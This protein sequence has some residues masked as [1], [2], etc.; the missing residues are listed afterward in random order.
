M[1]NLVSLDDYGVTEK[2]GIPVVSSRRVAQ[3][4]GKRHDNVL[5]A[6]DNLLNPRNGISNDFGLL[7]F[8][9]SHY[10]GISDGIG[11]KVKYKEYLLTRD[12]FTLLAMGFTGKK[13]MQFKISY[14]NAFNHMDQ[15]IKSLC[16]AKA[17]FPEFTD[18]IMLA[19]EE[20]KH[21]HFSNELDMINRIVLGMSA[22]QFREYNNLGK[23]SSIRPYLNAEQI[24]SIRKLQRVDIGLIVAV[25]DYQERKRILTQYH[26]GHKIKSLAACG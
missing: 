1:N 7:N 21:H 19:H 5:Q 4:F 3:V 9:V 16:E 2:N 11:K 6:I 25:P 14:I 15:F 12:G 8:K 24:D 17:D 13:A 23:V 20:P 22:K 18:A 10:Y 26:Q